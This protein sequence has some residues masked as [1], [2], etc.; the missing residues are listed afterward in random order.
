MNY[1]SDALPIELF[2]LFGWTSIFLLKNRKQLSNRIT[3]HKGKTIEI[4][5]KPN[6]DYIEKEIIDLKRNCTFIQC[7]I[8]N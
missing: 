8:K 5:S 7:H 2:E 3:V 1:K 6:N 4:I